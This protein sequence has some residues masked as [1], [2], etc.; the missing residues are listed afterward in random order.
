V[1]GGPPS[2]LL[3][4]TRIQEVYLGIARKLG[5]ASPLPMPPRTA[6]CAGEAS[7]RTTVTP[8]RS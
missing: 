8:R 4:E 5:R 3:L 7:A 6:D 1:A 2:A